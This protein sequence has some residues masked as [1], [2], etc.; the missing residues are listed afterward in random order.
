MDETRRLHYD[1]SKETVVD[2]ED[3]VGLVA[4]VGDHRRRDLHD[5]EGREPL[6]DDGQG[7]AALAEMEGKEF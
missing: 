1:R 4:D 6:D 3:D 2:G 5:Q 7:C